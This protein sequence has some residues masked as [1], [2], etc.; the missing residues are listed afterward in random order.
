[1]KTNKTL[2][3]L[4]LNGNQITN[5]GLLSIA[6]ALKDSQNTK[7]KN[8]YINDDDYINELANGIDNLIK[9]LQPTQPKV[10]PPK[11]VNPKL[12]P[13]LQYINSRTGINSGGT[14]DFNKKNIDDDGAILIADMLPNN[15]YLRL[16]ALGQNN[17][18]EKGAIALADAI[19]A[20]DKSTDLSY[21]RISNNNIGD[22]GAIA[23]ANVLKLNTAL[24][25]LE[26][27]SNNITDIGAIEIAE[28]LK[29]NT[30]LTALTLG[31][32]KISNTG[33]IALANAL[34]IN[35]TLKQLSIYG[36]NIGTDTMYEV[37][38]ILKKNNTIIDTSNLFWNGLNLDGLI[39]AYKPKVTQPKVTPPKVTQPKV[40]PPKVTQ[41][42]VT[43]PKVV[44][45]GLV[46][47]G[48]GVVPNKV[49]KYL[50][51]GANKGEQFSNTIEPFTQ[52]TDM[53][54]NVILII[55]IIIVIILAI[56]LIVKIN[57]K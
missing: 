45:P 56:L 15:P 2:T 1:L 17:I 33:M 35:K 36:N 52:K 27:N 48:A 13:I 44:D 25:N 29:I 49:L 11:I 43:R 28:A 54:T 38:I 3:R 4:Y 55:T 21:L 41:P 46:P 57:M 30:T 37:A 8:L 26:C 20:L 12:Q 50:E 53:T 19:A 16:L 40:T 34:S 24:T 5:T 9:S 42:K 39:A 10:T 23:L 31:A 7:L 18:G 14:W 47:W 22:N 6:Q 51:A 32:N